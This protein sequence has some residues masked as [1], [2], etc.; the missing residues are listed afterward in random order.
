MQVLK[1]DYIYNGNVIE[2]APLLDFHGNDISFDYSGL[3]FCVGISFH[4]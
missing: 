3:L 1:G 4:L 2:N